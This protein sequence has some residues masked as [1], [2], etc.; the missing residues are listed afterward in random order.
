MT[1]KPFNSIST[2]PHVK[3]LPIQQIIFFYSYTIRFCCKE[4]INFQQ[5]IIIETGFSLP[6]NI[7]SSS[8]KYGWMKKC[9]VTL[10]IAIDEP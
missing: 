4:L 1:S 9:D 8:R 2:A 10:P 5:C 7:E 6:N 3:G